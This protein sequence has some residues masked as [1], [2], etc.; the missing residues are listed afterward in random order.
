MRDLRI[1]WLFLVLMVACGHD[2]QRNG[3]PNETNETVAFDTADSTEPNDTA[4]DTT[5]LDTVPADTTP[6]EDGDFGASCR[7]NADCLDEWCVEGPEGFVCTREC[8]EQCPEGYDCKGVANQTDIVFLCIPRLLKQCTPC[9]D[10]LQCNGGVC[11]TIDGQ[12]GCAAPC[13]DDA[14]CSDGFQCDADPSGTADGTFCV[15]E[16]GSCSCNADID[17]GLRTCSITGSEG[18]CFGV[19]S[20]APLSGW[21]ACSVAPP[22]DEVCDGL[23]NDCDGLVDEALDTGSSCE[24]TVAGV[25]SCMGTQR[26]QGAAGLA[27]QGPTPTEETCDFIDNDCDGDIDED[28][29]TGEEYTSFAHCGTCNTSCGTGFVGAQLTQCQVGAGVPQCVVVVCEPGFIKLNDFQCIPEVVNLCQPCSSDANCIGQ[30]AA[31]VTLDDGNFCGAGCASNT[32]CPDGFVCDDVGKPTM[33]CVPSTGVCS[34]GPGTLGLARPC[35]V[36]VSPDGQPSYTCAGT[37]TCGA[38]GWGTCALPG[39]LC[40]GF[41]NNCDGTIDEDFKDAQGRYNQVDNCGGCNISCLAL[42]FENASPVCNTGGGG[43][44]NVTSHAT[45]T[46]KTSMDC[47]AASVSP[48]QPATC[49]T[50]TAWMP[51]ATESTAKSTTRSLWP[52]PEPTARRARSQRPSEPS[53]SVSIGPSEASATSMWRPAST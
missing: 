11:L 38:A 30:D 24:V 20:C 50:S 45:V 23:D 9:L 32:D 46:S 42:S 19:E 4:E 8:S 1:A 18:T 34:C 26:C 35:G 17:G 41:D 22:T 29:K 51:T 36:T 28:F 43:A 2:E 31:C 33:Q 12:R 3:N 15:P 47:R 21:G 13:D 49:L 48:A 14:P 53:R 37:E 27:C 16:T 25:G 7:T 52:R 6:P 40:D 39:E 10:D 44:P 5:P